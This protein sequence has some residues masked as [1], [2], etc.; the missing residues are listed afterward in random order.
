MEVREFLRTQKGI[1]DLRDHL[2][3]EQSGF[4]CVPDFLWEVGSSVGGWK[5]SIQKMNTDPPRRLTVVISDAD[6]GQ[7]VLRCD[8]EADRRKPAFRAFM[9]ERW[10]PWMNYGRSNTGGLQLETTAPRESC[11]ARMAEMLALAEELETEYK[12]HTQDS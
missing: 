8:V 1:K 6:D 4:A 2:D 3:S 10:P 9:D 11:A 5:L 7:R 12:R